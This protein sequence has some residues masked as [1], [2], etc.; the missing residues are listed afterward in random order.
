MI[1]RTLDEA[2][3]RF[4][5]GRE[6][7]LRDTRRWEGFRGAYHPDSSKTYIHVSWYVYIY[8]R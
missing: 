5:I 7:F 6:R 8:T 4:L 2:E 3:I 1:H